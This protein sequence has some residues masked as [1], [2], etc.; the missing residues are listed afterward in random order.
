MAG[1]ILTVREFELREDGSE[2]VIAE[3]ALP[4]L[5]DE[6]DVIVLGRGADV[7]QIGAQFDGII[8]RGISRRHC[9]LF[10]QDGGLFIKPIDGTVLNSSRRAIRDPELLQAGVTYI[11]FDSMFFRSTLIVRSSIDHLH[12]PSRDTASFGELQSIDEILSQLIEHR[13]AFTVAMENLDQREQEILRRL[14]TVEN[15][16]KKQSSILKRA[17][18]IGA[19]LVVG[20]LGLKSLNIELLSSISNLIMA[21]VAVAGLFV[22]QKSQK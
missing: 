8:R 17:I 20:A 21:G 2:V 18:V 9:I 6:G 1:L 5:G 7:I 22:S 10:Q 19:L 13:Q 4:E 16:D 3:F 14:A 15:N 11:L 12:E